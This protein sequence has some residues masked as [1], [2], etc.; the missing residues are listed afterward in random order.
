MQ[1]QGIQSW[2]ICT[3]VQRHVSCFFITSVVTVTAF[4]VY[5]CEGIEALAGRNGNTV[6]W[7]RK[8]FFPLSNVCQNSSWGL[9]VFC[10]F[11]LFQQ[12]CCINSRFPSASG[13]CSKW[14]PAVILLSHVTCL[15]LLIPVTCKWSSPSATDWGSKECQ[16]HKC[17][18]EGRFYECKSLYCVS[19]IIIVP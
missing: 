13:T 11:L 1:T 12:F 7:F 15:Q 3:P 14:I 10:T 6:E 16:I 4:P 8:V 2:G 18:F 17:I 5:S 9:C 19:C